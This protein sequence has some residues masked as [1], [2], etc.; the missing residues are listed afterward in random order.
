MATSRPMA[1]GFYRSRIWEASELCIFTESVS[2]TLQGGSI[3]DGLCSHGRFRRT[4]VDDEECPTSSHWLLVRRICNTSS[5]I[6][7]SRFQDHDCEP[8]RRQSD[9]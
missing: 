7:G 3:F 9:S 8:W 6:H 2:I 1:M 5:Q 4:S